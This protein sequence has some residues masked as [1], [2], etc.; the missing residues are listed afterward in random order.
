M[1]ILLRDFRT[2]VKDGKVVN[3]NIGTT[4]HCPG[5]IALL[6][7]YLPECNVCVWASAPLS[8]PLR[9]MMMRRFPK[10]RIVFGSLDGNSPALEEAAR[11]CDL[12]VGSGT[13]IAVS[14][15]VQAFLRF[16]G[17]PF[18]AVGI[19]FASKDLEL[20]EK[21]D[22]VFFRDSLALAAAEAAGVGVATGF[23]SDGA[24]EFDAA[25]AVGAE[26]F[27]ARHHLTPGKFACCLPRYRITPKWEF[28]PGATPPEDSIAYN[29]SMLVHDMTP[30]VKASCRVVRELG[31]KILLSPE[32]EPATRLCKNELYAMFPDDVKPYVEYPEAFW[33]ADLALGVYRQ[34]RGLF[35]TE[36]HSQVMAIGN[37]IPAIVCYTEGFGSKSHI[38]TDL[39]L[40]E[41]LFDF[42][43]RR[44]WE[45]FPDYVL[46]I[47]SEKEYVVK[48]MRLAQKRLKKQFS[49]FA[50]F[51]REKFMGTT[52]QSAISTLN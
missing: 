27:L 2:V 11:W 37:D 12:L 52:L 35:G 38:W 8:A 6:E 21:G 22:F 28:F 3:F 10:V 17:K 19:G 43:N 30:L 50:D 15:D 33:E 44:D 48:M 36:M 32:T 42:D 46:K 47:L 51:I 34:S 39:G 25:D 14:N 29:K 18:G 4:A 45:I 41:W 24:F 31:L 49:F 13:S 7:K 16:C 40:G 1:N 20:I 9:S 23:V 5:V 26:A